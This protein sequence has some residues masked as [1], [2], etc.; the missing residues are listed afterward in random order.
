MQNKK[1]NQIAYYFIYTLRK[2]LSIY[3]FLANA[4]DFR[5]IGIGFLELQYQK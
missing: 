4:D 1:M 5:K 3:I 2:I